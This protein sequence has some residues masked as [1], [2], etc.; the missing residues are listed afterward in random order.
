MLQLVTLLLLFIC[1]VNNIL[2]IGTYTSIIKGGE[3]S[4]KVLLNIPNE[5]WLLVM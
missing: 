3:V 2:I 4:E 5:Y 1:M